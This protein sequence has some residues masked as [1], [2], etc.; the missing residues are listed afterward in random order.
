MTYLIFI[1]AAVGLV[2]GTIFVLR[3]SI[4]A[5]CL[6]YLLTTS[7]FGHFFWHSNIGSVGLTL[8]RIVLVGLAVLFGAHQLARRTDPKRMG[9]EDGLLIATMVWFSIRTFTAGWNDTISG[10]IS[11]LWYLLAGWL[12]ASALYWFIRQSQLSERSLWLC[13]GFF[14]G[15]GAYL[16]VTG[17]LEVSGQWWAVFPRHIAD[18]TISQ[19]F[20]RARGPMVNSIPYGFFLSYCLL[21]AWFFRGQLQARGRLLLYALMIVMLAALYF[22]YT[23]CVWLGFGLAVMIVLWYTLP[24]QVSVKLVGGLAVCS[25]LVLSVGWDRIVSW[26]SGRVAAHA[27]ESSMMRYSFAYVGGMMFQDHPVAG[28]GFGQYIKKQIPYLADR[29]SGLYLEMIEDHPLHNLFLS[30]LVETG[31]I[32]FL[33][34]AALL[35]SWLLASWRLYHNEAAPPWARN[36][37]LMMLAMTGVYFA[38]SAFHPMGHTYMVQMLFFFTAGITVGLYRRYQ[39]V[40]VRSNLFATTEGSYAAS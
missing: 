29:Q 11:P 36:Q 22:S 19:H 30:I 3:G 6:A 28:C 24:R 8:D 18:P 34:F 35:G 15:L 31:L 1:A 33:L 23:R 21:A 38:H 37:G 7:V 39:P 32:G 25:A 12:S 4:M 14:I 5:G 10:Q 27:R 26:D 20:G 2:W 9:R 16:A 17:I 13:H 40:V